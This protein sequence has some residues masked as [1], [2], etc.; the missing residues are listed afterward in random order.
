MFT[1]EVSDRAIRRQDGPHHTLR[2]RK[3]VRQLRP[4]SLPDKQIVDAT[5]DEEELL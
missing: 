2:W 1:A 4:F 3:K 5:D